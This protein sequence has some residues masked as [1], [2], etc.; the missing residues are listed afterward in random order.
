V[1]GATIC[2]VDISPEVIE[3]LF[4]A[5]GS[6][7][8]LE[9]Y[10]EDLSKGWALPNGGGDT[11]RRPQQGIGGGEETGRM[12]LGLREAGACTRGGGGGGCLVM[13]LRE[14]ISSIKILPYV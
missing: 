2:G 6:R 11:Q 10:G 13:M 5:D 7:R 4:V 1:L 8:D 12:T 9:L 14:L 3:G